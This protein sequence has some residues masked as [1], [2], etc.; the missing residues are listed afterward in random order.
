MK[1]NDLKFPSIE[2]AAMRILAVQAALVANQSSSSELGILVSSTSELLNYES[3]NLLM[4]LESL[5]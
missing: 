5:K 3:I 2:K 1:P 4:L